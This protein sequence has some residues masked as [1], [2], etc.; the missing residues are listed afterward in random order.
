MAFRALTS[1]L[2][3]AG[4]SVVGPGAQM[5]HDLQAVDQRVADLDLLATSLFEVPNEL[6]QDTGF[7]RLYVDPFDPERFIRIDG[8][9]SASF[10]RSEYVR[11]RRGI[12]PAIPGGTEF[13]I[14]E[15]AAPWE[16][17][18]PWV[19]GGR[20]PRRRA[21]AVMLAEPVS[22]LVTTRVSHRQA[23][24]SEARRVGVDAVMG[25]PDVR[26]PRTPMS[27]ER[28]RARR[29]ASIAARYGA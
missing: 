1:V 5:L 21:Q 10:P 16:A 7:E 13:F 17:T 19:N 12:E 27:D 20:E 23:R 29:L 3:G 11:T 2:I 18:P 24:V 22:G 4:M 6:R 8:G 28:S 25:P 26:H 14:G 15:R 9:I